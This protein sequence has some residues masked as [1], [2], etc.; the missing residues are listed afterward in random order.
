[1]KA[2]KNTPS[3]YVGTWK[4]YNNGNLGGAW[5][6]LTDCGTY[7]G[8]LQRCKEIHCNEKD[9]EFM[10]QD[11]ENFPDG[12]D[13][14]D[15]LT[16]Q[17]FNDVMRD[18]MSSLQ[19]QEE[20]KPSYEI[21]D[22]SEK[23]FAVTGD[24]RSIK[25]ELKQ[26]GGRFN[27]KLKCGAGWIFSKKVME[28]VRKLL[29]SGN[30]SSSSMDADS[31]QPGIGDILKDNLKEYAQIANS[32]YYNTKNYVGAVKI[33]EAYYLIRKPKIENRFCFHDEGPNYDFYCSLM[34]DKKKLEQYFIS[35]NEN[36]FT[37]RLAYVKKELFIIT[38]DDN[39]QVYLSDNEYDIRKFYVGNQY[40]FHRATDEERKSII[41]AL[42]YGLSELRKRLNT[43]LKRYGTSKIHTWTY[44][45]DR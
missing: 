23:A 24:T 43:Y 4:K 28:D 27:A 42:E 30:V 36:E 25:D 7:D 19:E 1:M 44:W 8:F 41:E 17:E 12:L 16:E 21:V 10:V 29:E 20:E 18:Y 33:G 6:D 37:E 32:D 34:K 13:I 3:V 45:A 15:W 5:I 9:P 14:T 22:Y 26:L 39:R 40:K 2:T 38:D 11:T 31:N 35:E